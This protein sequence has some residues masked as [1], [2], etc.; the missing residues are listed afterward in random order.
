LQIDIANLDL[1]D[2]PSLTSTILSIVRSGLVVLVHVHAHVEEVLETVLLR[3][4]LWRLA[5]GWSRH[6]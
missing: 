4:P 2:A 1:P 3:N 5:V 6:C